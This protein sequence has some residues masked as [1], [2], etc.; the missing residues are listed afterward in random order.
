M[1]V[2]PKG[3]VKLA[4]REVVVQ[5]REEGQQQF[6]VNAKAGAFSQVESKFQGCRGQ[7]GLSKN[8][9]LDKTFSG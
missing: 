4:Y 5:T 3:M 1:G 6:S 9:F 7:R 8:T 2:A